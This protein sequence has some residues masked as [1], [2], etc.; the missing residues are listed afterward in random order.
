MN[1]AN[2]LEE[3]GARMLEQS[4]R[5]SVEK[6]R[7]KKGCGCIVIIVVGFLSVLCSL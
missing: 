2:I 3:H 5:K 7:K 1:W 4:V 6:N